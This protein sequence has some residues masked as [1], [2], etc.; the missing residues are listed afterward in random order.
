M[1]KKRL[2]IGIIV[3]LLI[4]GG[5]YLF[6]G[7][8]SKGGI[9][10]E[11][12]KVGRG[13]ITNTVTATGAV[14]PVTEVEVGTQVSGIIDKLYAD[15]NDVVKAGQLIAEMDKVNLKAELASAQAGLA[16]SKTEFEYQQKNYARSKVLYEKKLISDSD[17]ETATYNYEK[18]KAAYDQSQAAMVKV[19]RNLEYATITSPIDG[20]IIDRAVE[21][22]Q[23]VAAGFETPTLFTIAA[24]LTKMQVI[25]DV[26][27]ADIGNVQD[28]QRVSFTVDAYPNDVFEGKVKQIRLG[29]SSN[30]NTSSTSSSSTVVTYEVVITADNPDL[31]LKPRLT[32]NVTIYTMEQEN[33]LTI[34]TKALR[35]VPD[36][37]ILTPMGITVTDINK[38]TPAGKRLIWVKEGQK[39]Q[40]RTVTV[41]STSGNHIEITEGLK[42][43]EEIIVDLASATV[44]PSPEMA[45]KS[46]FMPG[47]PG[48]NKKK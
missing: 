22:G 31:K 4:I 8:S 18:A 12:A 45:E 37:N 32:A 11:T 43:G 47:P 21:E 48:S 10:L 30:S 2:I 42:E 26:D 7:K 44:T 28:G 5:V 9:K 33:V 39:L 46:P 6:M 20:V 29:D 1:N 23:T 27:E 38:E 25:A 24:D 41:G 40:P 17:Y 34:P 14:E 36:E 15:Y 16:S 35:F 13:S 19:N 3:M